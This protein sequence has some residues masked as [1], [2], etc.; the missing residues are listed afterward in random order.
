MNCLSSDVSFV[1]V[2]CVCKD[3][4]GLKGFARLNLFEVPTVRL[5]V[6]HLQ[7]RRSLVVSIVVVICI[8]TVASSPIVGGRAKDRLTETNYC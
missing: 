2:D 8:C 6:Y 1:G 7:G 4:W 5:S 3:L